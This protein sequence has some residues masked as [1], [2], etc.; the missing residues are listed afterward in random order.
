MPIPLIPI[1]L[2]A[3]SLATGIIAAA[4]KQ[5]APPPI[6]TALPGYQYPQAYPQAQ[7]LPPPPPI[8]L[9]KSAETKANERFIS[10]LRKNALFLVGAVFALF[11]FFKKK[12]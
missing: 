2:G 1:I 8:P 7:T 10:W 5:P 4:R 11:F 12:R 3:A 6:A 9:F